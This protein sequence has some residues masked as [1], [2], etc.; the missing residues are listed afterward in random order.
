[1]ET[2]VLTTE[3][4]LRKIIA[5]EFGKFLKR[6]TPKTEPDFLS[7]IKP[8]VVFLRDNGFEISESLF[9]KK[10]AKCDVPCKRFHNKRL[11]FSKSALL[12][13]AE[14]KCEPVGQGDAAILLADSANKK[15]NGRR[16]VKC[17]K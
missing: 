12:S 3:S 17:T 2:L 16:K 10:T 7:G 9:T 15:F 13:W 11:I 4:D 14:S 5:D 1:M 8:A 6:E